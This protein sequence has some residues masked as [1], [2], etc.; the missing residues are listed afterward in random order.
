MSAE[1]RGLSR[2][3][4]DRPE[5]P[6]DGRGPAS[7]TPGTADA[8]PEAVGTQPEPRGPHR[9][10][11]AP[12]SPWL[13]LLPS[14]IGP[15]GRAPVSALRSV[16]FDRREGGD[17]RQSM[18]VEDKYRIAVLLPCRD[19]ALTIG[20]VVADFARALP[21]A[22][23][24]VYDN[25]SSDDTVAVALAAGASVQEETKPGK[26]QVLYRMFSEIDADIYV[27]ADGDGT[28]DAQAAPLMIE[29]LVSNRLD[30][31]VGR[32]RELTSDLNTYPPGHRLGNAVLTGVVRHIFGQGSFDMLSG[33]RVL[34]RRYVK[35]FPASSRGFET[36]TEM[37]VHALNLQLPFSEIDTIYR[38]RPPGSHS[39]LRTVPDG[40]RILESVVRLVKDY[41]PAAFFGLIGFVFGLMTVL[42]R[43]AV[44]ASITSALSAAGARWAVVGLAVTT[45]LVLEAGIILDSVSRGRRDAERMMYLGVAGP[46]RGPVA[47][48]EARRTQ[49]AD[50]VRV[51]PKDRR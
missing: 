35:T 16:P 17:R 48:A 22:T 34:S 24:W 27:I 9:S 38:A 32:R 14:Q 31:V 12:G 11:D 30:M 8:I 23:I 45:G 29:E 18:E 41:R 20:E 4:R 44:Y 3:R 49:S 15:S 40:I 19:E 28:Y 36:E 47:P 10:G 50:Q 25:N 5:L 26:G 13:S 37:T 21:E 1:D 43:F 2:A 33:Y 6:G 51:G 7:A 42:A 46:G 39:K